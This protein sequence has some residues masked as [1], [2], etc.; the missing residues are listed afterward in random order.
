MPITIFPDRI[1]FN[2]YTL[3]ITNTGLRVNGNFG[4]RTLSPALAFQGSVRG[5][6]GGGLVGGVASNIINKFS[7]V[8]STAN[9]SDIADLSVARYSTS[10]Q[11]STT[12]GYTSS[13]RIFPTYSNVIDKFPFASDANA[14]D[15]GDTTNSVEGPAGH[16]D[17]WNGFGFMSAG[18][19]GPNSNSSSV[20]RFPFASNANATSVSSVTARRRVT[21]QSSFDYGYTTGGYRPSPSLTFTLIERFSLASTTPIATQG[22]LTQARMNSSGQSSLVSGY[23]TTGGTPAPASFN[24]IDKFPF[25]T[26]ANATDVGDAT[27]VNQSSAGHSST[28]HGYESGGGGA[29]PINIID[30]FPFASNANATDVGDLSTSISGPAGQ[31]F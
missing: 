16:S 11:S 7:F 1:E 20:D 6:T 2:N 13:G 14:T 27:K 26:L 25:A 4:V 31:Q 17:K 5:Y 28:T 23:T 21:G 8:T 12:D 18:Q 24:T 9:G 29:S 19:T 3:Y 22:D 15:V 10:G 30:R